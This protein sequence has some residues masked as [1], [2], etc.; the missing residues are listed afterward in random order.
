M[1]SFL[2]T[3]QPTE[4]SEHNR[5][6]NHAQEPR[7]LS[8]EQQMRAG[9]KRPVS[10]HGPESPGPSRETGHK[11]LKSTSHVDDHGRITKLSATSHP[12]ADILKRSSFLGFSTST[13]GA[14]NKN[15]T[16]SNYFRL[17]ALGI[18]R[19]D[20]AVRSRGTKRHLPESSQSSAQTSP[21]A[22]RSPSLPASSAEHQ[23]AKALMPPPS[24]SKVDNDDEALFARLKAARDNLK[25]ST[26][27]YDSEIV[28]DDQLSRSMN[29]SRSSNEHD[30]PSMIKARADAR[31]RSSQ[32]GS[33]MA[34]AST[35]H[36]VPAYR[37]R[38]SRFVPR[39]NYSK[40]IERAKEIRESRSRETSRPESRMSP[41]GDTLEVKQP[42]PAVQSGGS[43]YMTAPSAQNNAPKANGSGS[44]LHQSKEGNISS[45]GSKLSSVSPARTS[46]PITFSNHTTQM[47]NQN[48][49]LQAPVSNAFNS[50]APQEK[51]HFTNKGPGAISPENHTIQPAQINQALANSFGDSHGYGQ[52]RFLSLPQD[53]PTL[54]QQNSY[55]QSQSISLLSD[56]EDDGPVVSANRSQLYSAAETNATEE[57]FDEASDEEETAHGY[58]HAN[59]YELLA[60]QSDEE[61]QEWDSQMEDMEDEDEDPS[62]DV[63]GYADDVEDE[64]ADGVDGDIDEYETEEFDGD[65]EEDADGY[66]YDEEE[67]VANKPVH[68]PWVRQEYDDPWRAKPDPNPALQAIGN[69]AEEAIELSD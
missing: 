57:L 27:Y 15:T 48:P 6:R 3:E 13:T 41:T 49:F 42:A 2:S 26:S 39:E 69:T 58:G 44:A 56:D 18:N 1:G 62:E 25:D 32:V 24:M 35:Q 22:L 60:H 33:A 63:N 66:G 8:N 28:K 59:P 61:G 68:T 7:V 14:S 31:L 20:D 11:R 12:N 19:V 53:V 52:N 30:S 10:S 36:D 43:Q 50:F 34:L 64:D 46:V 47:S 5:S 51:S 9:S 16:M 17:K 40:A 45:F 29:S 38:E 67:E 23:S 54:P 55:L 65:E 37:L 4:G 21:P